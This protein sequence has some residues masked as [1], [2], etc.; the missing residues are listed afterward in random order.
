MTETRRGAGLGLA[1]VSAAAFGTA[2]S[3]ATALINAGW[4]PAAAVTARIGTAAVVLTIPALFVLWGRWARL[5]GASRRVGAFGVFAVVGAQVCFFNAIGHLSVG[6]ALLLEYLGTLL[7]VGWLWARHGQ[8]PRRLTVA[9][10]GAAVIG[11]A[12]VLDVSG[13]SRL[14][15]VGVLWG[16]G[17]AIG[18]AVYFVLSADVEDALPPIALTWAGMTV[19]GV[20]LAFLGVV[21]ALPMHARFG[22]V[23][24]IGHRT[25]WL[26]PVLGLSVL[27]AAFSY[28]VGIESVRMLGSKLAS[29]AGLSEVLFAVL[30]AWILLDQLPR[31]TQIL[32]G[33]FILGGVALVRVDELR[34]PAD[35]RSP[36]TQ[37]GDRAAVG[38]SA[39][40]EFGEGE[41]GV[42]G[43][44]VGHEQVVVQVAGD[45]V[46]ADPG[47]GE[48]PADRRGQSDGCERR[49]HLQGD[50]GRDE[51]VSQSQL[52]GPIL[53]QDQGDPLVLPHHDDRMHAGRQVARDEG[54]D[55]PAGI[56]PGRHLPQQRAQL[57]LPAGG[58]S[59]CTCMS[60]HRDDQAGT[61][62]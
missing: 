25:S 56:Q 46:G 10:A 18:L 45:D 7:V 22:D 16:L 20:A 33:A 36:M 29:F 61:G 3:F 17:A 12:L 50:P 26:V 24:F 37:P 14:D 4:S 60:R 53:G 13:R 48:S 55:V 19:G 28:V 9:G 1:L 31:A 15:P 21:G 59:H 38:T 57:G 32:G 27:A 35:A 49:A 39:G 5:A 58:L 62:S 2:G 47:F 30:F 54:E 51:L 6:V 41:Q 44:I 52:V 23:A 34:R 40:V 43:P 11:L 42:V 8:R